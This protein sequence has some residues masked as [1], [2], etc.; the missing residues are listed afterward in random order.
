MMKWREGWTLIHQQRRRPSV[1]A[2]PVSWRSML[3]LVALPTWLEQPQQKDSFLLPPPAPS[4]LV[5]N[6]SRR[7]VFTNCLNYRSKFLR[8]PLFKNLH[9]HQPRLHQKIADK[10]PYSPETRHLLSDW[11]ARER[12]GEEERK[13]GRG[14]RTWKHYLGRTLPRLQEKRLDQYINIVRE[15]CVC[16]S[17]CV[18]SGWG[19]GGLH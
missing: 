9:L 14:A 8:S 11:G 18:E 4:V 19:G 15:Q 1:K 17:V 3:P 6:A 16:V 7:H 2:L 13:R 12:E 10:P 5:L